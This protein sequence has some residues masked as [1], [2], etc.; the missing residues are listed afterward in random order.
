MDIISKIKEIRKEKG[1]KQYDIAEKLGVDRSNYGYLEKRGAKL[2]I[3]QLIQIAEAL[4]VT[5]QE[6]LFEDVSEI[7]DLEFAQLKQEIEW[8]KKSLEEK[9]KRITLLEEMVEL[10]KEKK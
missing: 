9:E 1:L 6:I 4:G 5:I 3:E 8:L 10:L 7:P 2:T